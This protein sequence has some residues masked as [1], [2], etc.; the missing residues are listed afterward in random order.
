MKPEFQ[1]LLSSSSL[2]F[3]ITLKGAERNML[4]EF[5][6]QLLFKV[7]EIISMR[8]YHEPHKL[9]E[10]HKWLSGSNLLLFWA[11]HHP[12]SASLGDGLGCPKKSGELWQ[13]IPEEVL[14]KKK[15]IICIIYEFFI[16]CYFLHPTWREVPDVSITQDV[17]REKKM[18]YVIGWRA[19]NV[20]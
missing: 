14:T 4:M 18:T 17:M 16:G 8:T 15:N 1:G 6:L 12:K 11:S 5:Y 7:M 3:N 2:F 9:C 10:F 19:G 20:S 13:H